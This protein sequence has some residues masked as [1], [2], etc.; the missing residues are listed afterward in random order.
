MNTEL[1]TEVRRP[2][3]ALP[4]LGTVHLSQRETRTP[5]GQSYRSM[6]ARCYYPVHPAF[7]RYGGRGIRVCDRWLSSFA[8]FVRDMG[9]RPEGT[10]LDRYPNNDGNYEPGNCRWATVPTQCR[11]TSINRLFNGKTLAE[12]SEI[13]GVNPSTLWERYR[14]GWPVSRILTKDG[15]F[16]I[17]CKL[18]GRTAHKRSAK[19]LYCSNRC[20]DWRCK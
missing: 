8:D 2:K 10:S 16:E 14:H 12:W 6:I 17:T 18:C 11:N 3:A 4:S 5:E 9:P 20:K 19:A 13:L 7:H 1:H 15:S